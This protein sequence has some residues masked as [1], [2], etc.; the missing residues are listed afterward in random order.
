[1]DALLG[2][3]LQFV[4][5]YLTTFIITL[6]FAVMVCGSRWLAP[7]TQFFLTRPLASFARL[8]K[9]ILGRAL[10]L[11]MT[12]IDYLAVRV[13]RYLIDPIARQTRALLARVL[14]PRRH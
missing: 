12:V 14:F 6:G 5:F 8:I 1:M 13:L 4:T 9:A 7:V 2:T 10:T 11:A 3:A